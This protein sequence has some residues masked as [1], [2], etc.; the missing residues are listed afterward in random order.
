MV[1]SVNS[2]RG[3]EKMTREIVEGAACVG[4]R[5]GGRT[6]RHFTPIYGIPQGAARTDRAH[7]MRAYTMV[8]PLNRERYPTPQTVTR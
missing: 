1:L 2:E 6:L 7:E 8:M 5:C 4:N 3:K